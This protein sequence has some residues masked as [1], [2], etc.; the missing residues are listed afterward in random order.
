LK[1]ARILIAKEKSGVQLNACSDYG[2]GAEA[3]TT[4]NGEE[5]LPASSGNEISIQPAERSTS[6][7][8][9]N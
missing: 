6:I 5:G 3:E 9:E 4:E 8:S 7:S 1:Q 2:R